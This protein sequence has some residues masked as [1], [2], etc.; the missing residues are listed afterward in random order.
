MSSYADAGV[1]LDAADSAVE[2]IKPHIARTRR[3]EV[4]ESESGFGAFFALDTSRYHQPLLVT[5]TDGVG[6][7]LEIAQALDRHDTIGRDL[8]AMVVDDIVCSGAA[9]LLFLDYLAVS[10][11]DPVHAEQV[12]SGI[13]DACEEVGCAL[14]GGEM[15]A[16]PGVIPPGGYDLAGFGLG[17]VER[18]D[19]LDAGRVQAGDDLVAMAST[20]LHSNGYSL[21]RRIVA[22]ARLDLALDH[23]LSVQSLGDALLRPTRLYAN[24]C[25][26][27]VAATRVH[28]L[29]HVTGGGVPGNLARILPEG[30]GAG[31]DTA[32]FDVPEV[33]RLLQRHGDV[34]EAEMWRVFNMGAGMLAAVPDGQRAVEV[35]AARGLDAWVCGRV[36]E[37]DGVHL[38]G[39]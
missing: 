2:A 28:A 36:D 5:S 12:V 6:T 34:A 1:D 39:V 20:G 13:A 35:L 25:L 26:A 22:D 14:V 19:V 7:K 18:D 38:D 31:I 11:L 15:A 33:L 21:A 10:T 32:T 8:V 37:G 29:A 27:L 24:D 3:P 16:H 17:I 4:L 9:P 23:G 30:L